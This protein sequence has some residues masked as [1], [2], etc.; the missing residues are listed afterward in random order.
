MQA[1]GLVSPM[2]GSMSVREADRIYITKKGAHMGDLKDDDILELPSDGSTLMAGTAAADLPAHIAIYKDT[3]FNAV[4][5]AT[6]PYALALSLAMEN[7]IMPQDTEGLN[8]LRSIPVVRTRDR[9][10][11]EELG[12]VLPPIYKS[13]YN[14]SIVKEFG[15][16]A[17]GD[18]LFSALEGTFCLERSCKIISVNKM[19]A[20]PEPR[21]EHPK[22]RRSAI[23]PGIGVM[24]R[25]R[26]FKRGF[27]R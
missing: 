27:N 24:D 9:G 19:M 13:G 20:T 18:N 26:N 1:L 5:H 16:Y 10:N 4:V 12:K 14:V 25:D 22:E 2:G 15:S 17:V 7:K 8:T 21:R 6:P 11:M 23:P 3:S